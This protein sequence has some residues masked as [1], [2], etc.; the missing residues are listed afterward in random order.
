MKLNVGCGDYLADGW[1]NIDRTPRNRADVD[2]SRH[3]YFT[4][5]VLK[6]LPWGDGACERIY[7]GHVLE[8]LRYDDELPAALAEMKRL[9]APDGVLCVVGPD[10]DRAKARYPDAVPGIWPGIH[11]PETPGA[12]HQ[13]EPTVDAHARALDAAGFSAS[14]VPI[15]YVEDTWPVVSRIGWQLAYYCVHSKVPA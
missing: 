14:E 1:V 8:H 7:A 9:L 3:H 11:G 5:D 15:E 6:G 2:L 12:M 13:W 10:L 4:I